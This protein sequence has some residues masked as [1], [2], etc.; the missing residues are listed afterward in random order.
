MVSMYRGT[1]GLDLFVML[2]VTMKTLMIP[3]HVR[4]GGGWHRFTLFE[5][6]I[7]TSIARN[8]FPTQLHAHSCPASRKEDPVKTS[9]FVDP[10]FGICT[11]T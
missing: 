9:R 7:C 3:V 4:E 6:Y 5:N 11:M 10:F 1:Y 2:S 8:T